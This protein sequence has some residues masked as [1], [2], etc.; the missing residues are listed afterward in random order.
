MIELS[1]GVILSAAFF[2]GA[3]ELP[4]SDSRCFTARSL[5]NP[6]L[7]NEFQFQL[8][9]YA[10]IGKPVNSLHHEPT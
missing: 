8:Q 7:E 4:R 9:G 5:Q 2:S 3:K 6:N 10:S 1:Q